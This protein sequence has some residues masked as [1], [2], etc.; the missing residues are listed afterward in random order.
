[1]EKKEEVKLRPSLS[2]IFRSFEKSLG[3]ENDIKW[4]NFILITLYHILFIY[5]PCHYALP[6]KWQTVVFGEFCF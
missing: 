1:M 6:V 3:F 2:E 5:W 4:V